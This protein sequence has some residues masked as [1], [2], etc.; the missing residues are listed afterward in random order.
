M[1]DVASKDTSLLGGLDNQFLITDDKAY[2]LAHDVC[3]VLTS[4]NPSS[5]DDIFSAID[6]LELI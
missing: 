3:A 4:G 1:S 5:G 2:E 6:Y